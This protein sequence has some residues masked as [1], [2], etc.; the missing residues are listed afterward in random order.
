MASWIVTCTIVLSVILSTLV[1]GTAVTCVVRKIWKSGNLVFVVPE[2]EQPKVHWPP[3]PPP[4]PPTVLPPP[5]RETFFLPAPIPPAIPFEPTFS[6]FPPW[7]A[8]TANSHP[9]GAVQPMEEQRC[10]RR[11]AAPL[12]SRSELGS[13]TEEEWQAHSTNPHAQAFAG[14]GQAPAPKAN[15]GP[16]KRR[17]V[18]QEVHYERNRITSTA[19][20]TT[21]PRLDKL[22]CHLVVLG[23][24]IPIHTGPS[25]TK[26]AESLGFCLWY[27]N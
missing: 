17:T 19:L 24:L 12:S 20:N 8:R 13:T 26:V 1:V 27:R 11:Q 25:I 3:P 5:V 15:R 14:C 22:L 2:V 21:F 10:S 9:P 4:V 16:A 6:V 23:R 18:P 7:Q